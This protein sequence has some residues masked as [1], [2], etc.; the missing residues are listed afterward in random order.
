MNPV[1]GSKP[2]G[3]DLHSCGAQIPAERLLANRAAEYYIEC[4]R[5]IELCPRKKLRG[6][7]PTM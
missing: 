6:E 7:W 3:R 1:R 5:D 2:A 4:Q